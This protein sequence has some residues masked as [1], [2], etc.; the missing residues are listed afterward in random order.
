L[1]GGVD[2]VEAVFEPVNILVNNAGI[3]HSDSIE[4]FPFDAYECVTAAKEKVSNLVLLLASDE[5]SYMTESEKRIDGG[6]TAR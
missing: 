4:D 5:L 2:Q 6:L 1:A 3:N